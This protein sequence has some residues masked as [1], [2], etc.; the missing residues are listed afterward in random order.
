MQFTYAGPWVNDINLGEAPA[1]PLLFIP[2][3]V[4]YDAKFSKFLELPQK[5][6]RE[7]ATLQSLFPAHAPAELQKTE[8]ATLSG[9]RH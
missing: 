6:L 4:D 2:A 1:L 5:I 8:T 7:K 3:S 9:D